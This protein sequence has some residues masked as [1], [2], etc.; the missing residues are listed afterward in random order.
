MKNYHV[1]KRVIRVILRVILRVII[2]GV[3][4]VIKLGLLRVIKGY[5][6]SEYHVRIIK[7]Y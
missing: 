1:S 6:K 2:K 4:R 5:H 3:I 7:G